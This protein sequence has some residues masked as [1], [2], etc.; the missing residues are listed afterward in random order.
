MINS[1]GEEYI[2]GI[3]I[4]EEIANRCNLELIFGELKFPKYN[5]PKDV[6]I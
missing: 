2:D 4:T 3:N 5:I 6:K 1:I